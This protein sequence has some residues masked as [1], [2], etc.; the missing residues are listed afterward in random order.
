MS[1]LLN[2]AMTLQSKQ[3]DVEG[4]VPK[5]ISAIRAWAVAGLHDMLT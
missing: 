4:S 1:A 3:L 5:E 2:V